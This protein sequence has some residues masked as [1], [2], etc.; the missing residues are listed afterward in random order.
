MSLSSI[1]SGFSGAHRVR[2]IGAE[3]WVYISD[4]YNKV[5]CWDGRLAAS[6]EAGLPG[7]TEAPIMSNYAGS[8]IAT[9]SFASGTHYLRYRY[10]NSK[11]Q[12]PSDASAQV[13]AVI[14]EKAKARISGLV[15]SAD[16][17][18][19][20]IVLEMTGA[21]GSEFYP[22]AYITN[23]TRSGAEEGY[24]LDISDVTLEQNLLGYEAAGNEPP[25]I[26]RVLIY[27]KGIMFSMCPEWHY[28]GNATGSASHTSVSFGSAGIKKSLELGEYYFVPSG[29][30]KAYEIKSVDVEGD[31]GVIILASPLLETFSG[32]S[33]VI[34]PRK[35]NRIYGSHP[36]FPESFSAFKYLD[37]LRNTS[38]I[39]RAAAPYR[40]PMILFGE[41][42]MEVWN[43]EIDPFDLSD[44][45]L[46]PIPGGR[47]AISQECVLWDISG[48]IYAFDY[49][50]LHRYAGSKIEDLSEPIRDYLRAVNWAK[51][52]LFFMQH[53]PE[54]ECV[55]IFVCFGREEYPQTAL[56]FNTRTGQWVTHYYDRPV[57]AGTLA[58]DGYGKLRM[59]VGTNDGAVFYAGVG[60]SDGA[61]PNYKVEGTVATGATGSGFA[62]VGGGLY[63]SGQCLK[64]VGVYLPSLGESSCITSNTS[65]SV[66]VSPAF[67]SS[68][69]PGEAVYIGRVPFAYRTGLFVLPQVILDQKLIKLGIKFT[70]LPQ[71]QYLYVKVYEDGSTAAK[72]TWVSNSRVNGVRFTSGDPR[73]QVDLSTAAGRVEIPLN[74]TW[75]QSIQFEFSVDEPGVPLQILGCELIG[76]QG[77]MNHG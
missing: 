8:G 76:E 64:G 29:S 21:D 34:E 43:W 40:G 7:P 33:Y 75:K 20:Q 25:P 3:G 10:W 59:M 14:I 65:G 36:L 18:V 39:L 23:T 15:A 61:Y 58:P 27:H 9:G 38:D 12:Y 30:T 62:V 63:A 74:I 67:T 13:E 60:Y 66:F 55:K 37:V 68:P 50:G 46:Y 11:T 31:D 70:V 77:L 1:A 24:E 5:R 48:A 45:S 47:G 44:A 56:V 42:N 57:R 28:E 49:R 16:P 72:K 51:A 17:R 4:G 41:R 69:G 6:V 32:A 73:I 19:D 22:A 54:T 2:M 53:D 52:P 35:A 26:G 71:A